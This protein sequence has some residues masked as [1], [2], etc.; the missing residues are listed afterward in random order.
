M[1]EQVCPLSGLAY[2]P[3]PIAVTASGGQFVAW[4]SQLSGQFVTP[5]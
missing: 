5:G 4:A 3:M 1:I 2:N